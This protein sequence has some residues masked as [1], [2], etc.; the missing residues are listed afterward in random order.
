MSAA[1]TLVARTD[2][3][4]YTRIRDPRLLVAARVAWGIVIVLAVALFV[5]VLPLQ[6]NYWRT[7]CEVE[8]CPYDQLTPA[9]V[10]VFQQLGLSLDF[11]ARYTT[12]LLT[13]VLSLYV[14]VAV[15]IFWRRSDN[16]LAL[17]VSLML[18]TN[19]V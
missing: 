13:A 1:V 5:A 3:T 10:S 9:Q 14:A 8:P 12:I 15:L 11:Y 16:W 19:A 6:F 4:T 2:T 17:S 7:V 18:V